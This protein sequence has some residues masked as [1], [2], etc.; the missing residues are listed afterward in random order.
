M[1]RVFDILHKTTKASWILVVCFSLQK[2]NM[3]KEIKI[4]RQIKSVI[5]DGNSENWCCYFKYNIEDFTSL[6]SYYV[7]YFKLFLFAKIAIYF[8]YLSEICTSNI[9]LKTTVTVTVKFK[10]HRM[11]NKMTLN[12]LD[13]KRKKYTGCFTTKWQ[14]RGCNRKYHRHYYILNK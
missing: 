11:I 12:N 8:P 4:K 7:E 2:L 13:K 6:S 1:K 14:S 3:S 10:V 9:K 5:Q